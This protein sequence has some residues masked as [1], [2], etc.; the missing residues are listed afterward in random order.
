MEMTMPSACFLLGKKKN[1]QKNTQKATA[2]YLNKSLVFL[3]T[4]R[5]LRS[6]LNTEENS[7]MILM[8]SAD[9]GNY[10]VLVSLLCRLRYVS[11]QLSP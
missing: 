3:P 7:H 11:T 5:E 4:V 9:R 1:K 6:H 8:K 2:I 10:F